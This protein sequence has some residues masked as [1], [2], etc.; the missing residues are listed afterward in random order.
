MADV[1]Q[2]VIAIVKTGGADPTYT[3]SLST[4]NVYQFTNDGKTFIH[5][6]NGGGSPD[7]VTIVS[8]NSEDGLAVADRTVSVT[9][10]E[11]R[12]IGPLLPHVYND[13]DG[14]V[15]FSHSFITTVTQ[16]VFSL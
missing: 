13:G 1:S 10:G 3:G 5:V 12:M 9:A 2:A 7:V 6:K 15:N 14:L 11:E 16:A 8:Q 4:G